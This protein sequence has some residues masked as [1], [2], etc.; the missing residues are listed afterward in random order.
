MG[1]TSEHHKTYCKFE[2]N[3]GVRTKLKACVV[4]YKILKKKRESTKKSLKPQFHSFLDITI[5][6]WQNFNM[7]VTE[8]L[9]YFSRVINQLVAMDNHSLR[10]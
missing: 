10:I 1:D 8:S 5:L 2:L 3:D 9:S 4:V 7:Q 6:K